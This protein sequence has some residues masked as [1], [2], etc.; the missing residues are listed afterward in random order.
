MKKSIFFFLLALLIGA[1]CAERGAQV[2]TD[3]QDE[4]DPS[5]IVTMEYRVEGMTCGGC[6]NTVNYA[7]EGLHGVQEVS[8]SFADAY[9]N[10]AF[11]TL[12]VTEEMIKEAVTSKGY[13]WIGVISDGDAE[14]EDA[15]VAVEGAE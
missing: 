3:D 10:I 12:L 5:R 2:M 13:T 7:I 11:D 1:G 4:I 6:E 15:S 8:S 14:T 9:V